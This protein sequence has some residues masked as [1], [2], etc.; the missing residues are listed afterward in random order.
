MDGRF[1]A[2]QVIRATV[3][4]LKKEDEES[5]E[6][7]MHILDRLATE[8]EYASHDDMEHNHPTELEMFRADHK[9]VQEAGFHDAGELL[10]AYKYLAQQENE[11]RRNIVDLGSKLTTARSL[12]R[13]ACKNERVMGYFK[14]ILSDMS[15]EVLESLLKGE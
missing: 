12:L 13:I 5:T 6:K 10:A 3:I 8:L 7:A 2:A 9:A 15:L 11:A 4:L 14:L 1:I